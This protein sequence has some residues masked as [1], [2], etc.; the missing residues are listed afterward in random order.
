MLK[1]IIKLLKEIDEI[2]KEDNPRTL[3]ILELE[4][5]IEEASIIYE[6]KDNVAFYYGS[7]NISIY[8]KTC[9]EEGLVI[10]SNS[11][12]KLCKAGLDFFK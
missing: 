12:K 2:K 10:T 7:G 4:D 1:D 3:K 11:F 8:N 9:P 6:K 5:K